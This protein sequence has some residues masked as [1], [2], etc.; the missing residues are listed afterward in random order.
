M[1]AEAAETAIANC[2]NMGTETVMLPV[3]KQFVNGPTA[4]S[5]EQTNEISCNVKMGNRNRFFLIFRRFSA[6]PIERAIEKDFGMTFP[7][8]G[9]GRV[10]G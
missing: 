9:Y 1:L 7:V 6:D 5:C 3:A 8:G 10:A 2:E 4:R